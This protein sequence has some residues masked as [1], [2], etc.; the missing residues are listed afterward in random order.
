[1]DPRSRQST[2]AAHTQPPQI[3]RMVLVAT[4]CII[5]GCMLLVLFGNHSSA[6]YSVDQLL[7]L[8]RQ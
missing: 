6:E 1:M 4:G 7:D 2:T 5:G 8:Y 3:T